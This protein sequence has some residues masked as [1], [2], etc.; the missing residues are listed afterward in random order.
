MEVATTE[1]NLLELGYLAARGSAPQ[2]LARRAALS[3]LRRKLT[4]LA[5]DSKSV[6]EATGRLAKGASAFPTLGLAMLSILET[7]GCEE[8]LTT[9]KIPVA[10]KWRFKISRISK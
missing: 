3:R 6:E 2:R 9:E 5:L 8:L 1:A 7:N 10:G 4:V